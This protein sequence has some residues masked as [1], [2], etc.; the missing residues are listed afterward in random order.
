MCEQAQEQRKRIE[1]LEAVL[2]QIAASP[3]VDIAL[4]KQIVLKALREG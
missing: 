4:I 3:R 1:E 2:E